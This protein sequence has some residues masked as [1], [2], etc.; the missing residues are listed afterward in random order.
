MAAVLHPKADSFQLEDCEFA[1]QV[2]GFRG[3]GSRLNV[4]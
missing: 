1:V 2:K 4:C 3:P